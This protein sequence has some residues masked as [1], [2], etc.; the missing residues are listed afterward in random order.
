MVFPGGGL[1]RA[2]P[3][4]RHKNAANKLGKPHIIANNQVWPEP[5][6]TFDPLR[7]KNEE[8]YVSFVKLKNMNESFGA[9]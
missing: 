1:L 2:L 7:P 9:T 6:R 8:E 4:P 5:P 3:K